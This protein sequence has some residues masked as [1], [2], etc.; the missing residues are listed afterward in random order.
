MTRFEKKVLE[1]VKKY[2]MLARGDSVLIGLY[3]G[4]DSVSLL[5]ALSGFFRE[6][7]ELTLHAIYIDHG[8]RPGDAPAEIEPMVA[9]IGGGDQEDLLVAV[10]VDDFNMPGLFVRV[11]RR[12]DE[13]RRSAGVSDGV[14]ECPGGVG[15]ARLVEDDVVI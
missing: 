3:G 10:E 8:L 1:T 14:Y 9:R 12:E 2:A 15:V 6:E 7:L 5:K 13:W 4:A 11:G